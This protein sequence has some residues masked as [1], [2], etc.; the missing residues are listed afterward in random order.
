MRKA[1]YISAAF[2]LSTLHVFSQIPDAEVF[3]VIKKNQAYGPKITSLLRNQT[4]LAW[5][6]DEVRRENLK[7][8]KTEKELLA[9]Q[10]TTREKLLAMIGGLPEEKTP[11]RPQ[12]QGKIQM[13][14]FHI[15]KLVFESVPGFFVT[16]LVYVPENGANK[17]PAV[18]VACGH[19]PIGK[20][21]YQALCQRLVQRGYLVICWDPVGQAERS[22]FWDDGVLAKVVIILSAVNMLYLEI[23]LI[24]QEPT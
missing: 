1:V 16:A 2:I 6:Q 4:A 15:E 13:N 9:L 21:Y 10:R 14:G 11:L 5:K 18:L 24:S 20:I 3:T 22:Q 19:S 23:L 8:I 12:I 17:H 7:N